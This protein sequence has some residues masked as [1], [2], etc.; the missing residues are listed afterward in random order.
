MDDK[1]IKVGI[2][3]GGK[4]A[5]HEISLISTKTVYK[6]IDKKKFKPVLI[7]INRKGTWSHIN[8]KEFE[9][10]DLINKSYASF[11][12][13][14]N[15]IINKLDID[16][17]F[18]VLHG[19]NCEDGK[20]QSLLE[21]SGKPYV[22]AN[23]LASSIAMDKVISKILFK[24]AGLNTPDFLF[25]TFNDHLK[26]K[27]M[28]LK[29]LCYP[30]FIK[31]C[32]LGSSVGI[33]KVNEEKELKSAIDLAFKYD[34]KIIIEK[35]INA[36]EIEIAV[37]GN[38][39]IKISKPG[40]LI[41]FNKFYDYEDKYVLGKTKFKIPTI[42]SNELKNKIKKMAKKAYE[43][44]FLNGM[45]RIDFFIEK[46]TEELFI[47]E[48]NTIPGFTEISMFPKLWEYEGIGFTDLI[49]KLIEYGFDYHRK[50]K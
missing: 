7:Y 1:K 9:N 45:A 14:E 46:N 18:P 28:I 30:V 4:S 47:N 48:I 34:K 32:S 13:W 36:R 5:E 26:I 50:Q 17:Y 43:S 21:L 24:N 6:Y 20:L 41:P 8:K 22:G 27:G 15:N 35:A 40:E 31:P 3:F 23:S 10:S 29:K 38:D 33:S 44:L 19:P 39:D 25:F 37:M 49:T 16:I 11:L 2:L 12:P 42:L